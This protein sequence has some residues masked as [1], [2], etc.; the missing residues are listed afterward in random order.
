M[1][2]PNVKTLVS[3]VVLSISLIA[4]TPNAEAR[5]VPPKFSL[6]SAKGERGTTVTVTGQNFWDRC[7]DVVI[8]GQAPRVTAGA[9]SIKILLKQGDKSRLL[10][11]VDAD[12]SLRFSVSVTIPIDASPGLASIV[13]E[14]DAYPL[15]GV[16]QGCESPEPVAFEIIA[17]GR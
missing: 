9:K 16:S 17:S 5:C 7:N 3:S 8:P 13:A 15:C 10:A 2:Q 1:S 4:F 14:A 12:A 11:T 6:S